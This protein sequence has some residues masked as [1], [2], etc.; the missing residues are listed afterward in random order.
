[1]ELFDYIMSAPET[2]TKNAEDK[3]NEA[4]LKNKTLEDELKNVKKELDWVT[5][6]YNVLVNASFSELFDIATKIKN[7]SLYKLLEQRNQQKPTQ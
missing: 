6:Q 1:V 2:E 7:A 5:E 4:V 3:L